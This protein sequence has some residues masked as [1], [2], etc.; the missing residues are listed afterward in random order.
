MPMKTHLRLAILALLGLAL[1]SVGW[2]TYVAHISAES[3][4]MP[5]ATLGRDLSAMTAVLACALAALCGLVRKRRVS[6]L[7]VFLAALVILAGLVPR[8]VPTLLI[9]CMGPGVDCVPDPFDNLAGNMLT[10][11]ALIRNW[12]PLVI[13]LCGLALALA[14]W[15]RRRGGKA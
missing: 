2:H 4:Y 5:P 1:V 6:H 14:G 7:V 15:P 13:L 11:N 8:T 12:L 3:F 9:Y 10:L